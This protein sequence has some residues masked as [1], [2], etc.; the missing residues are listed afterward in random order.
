MKQAGP[1]E[2]R[3]HNSQFMSLKTK[4]IE[5]DYSDKEF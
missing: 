5:I 2:G 3:E 4:T 1:N